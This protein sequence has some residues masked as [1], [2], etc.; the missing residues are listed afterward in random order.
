MFAHSTS[1]IHTVV[2][3]VGDCSRSSSDDPVLVLAKRHNYLLCLIV[4]SP[5]FNIAVDLLLFLPIHAGYKY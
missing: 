5:P 2:K 1:V 3:N 4:L